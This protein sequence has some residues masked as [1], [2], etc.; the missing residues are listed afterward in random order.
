M[1]D[2]L[3][4]L[5]L[6][7]NEILDTWKPSVLYAFQ[8]LY[9]TYEEINTYLF[10]PKAENMVIIM[11]YNTIDDIVI[12]GKP[13][14]WSM[15]KN[16]NQFHGI[17]ASK[18]NSIEIQYSNFTDQYRYIL[19]DGESLSDVREEL[20][21]QVSDE[22][23]NPVVQLARY[24]TDG[25]EYVN[26]TN[27]LNEYTCPSSTSVH[28][29]DFQWNRMYHAGVCLDT[30]DIYLMSV[31]GNEYFRTGTRSDVS[32]DPQ[33]TDASVIDGNFVDE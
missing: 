14:E 22:R 8:K 3:A 17:V 20:I 7:V 6:Y 21:W 19:E 24:K 33:A 13:V 5:K 18:E 1:V 27:E 16:H 29:N 15:S 10:V 31:D 23:E 32:Y 28:I 25:G 2:N 26:I 30:C 11:N 12:N 4:E 9:H